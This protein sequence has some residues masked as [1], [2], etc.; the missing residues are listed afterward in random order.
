MKI[1]CLC[2]AILHSIESFTVEHGLSDGS[3]LHYIITCL[4]ERE[5]IIAFVRINIP[6]VDI[7]PLW[8]AFFLNFV[9]ISATFVWN[10]TDI[11]IMIVSI[12]LTTNFK[13]INRELELANAEVS[14][15]IHLNFRLTI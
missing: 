2:D 12:G 11:F 1:D 4:R 6:H 8:A 13:L 7:I 3:L 9:N 14:A 5:V 10:Y 15:K